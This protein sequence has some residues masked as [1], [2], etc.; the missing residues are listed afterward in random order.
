MN[1]YSLNICK[2]CNN[3]NIRK[4]NHLRWT[5]CMVYKCLHCKNHW[6]VCE[7]HQQ[8][9]SSS[10]KSVMNKHFCKYHPNSKKNNVQCESELSEITTNNNLGFQEDISYEDI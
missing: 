8:R 1:S 7:L 3:T 9:F 10:R 6:F 5:E 4:T 2:Q